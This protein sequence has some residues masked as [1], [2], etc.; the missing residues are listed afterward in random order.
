MNVLVL[1]PYPEA[2]LPALNEFKDSWIAFTKPLSREFCLEKNIDF[3]I[4]YG[5]RHILNNEVL[6]LFPQK[7]I[8]LHM[9]MLPCSR[10]AHPNFWSIAEGMP[11]GVTIHLLDEGLDTGNILIQREV[12]LDR[13][14]DTF[15]SSYN[16]L[17][18]SIEALF[19]ANW[20]YLRTAESPGWKQQGAP[21]V[22]RSSE[23]NK[24]LD[25]LPESWDT[26]IWRFQQLAAMRSQNP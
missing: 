20:K 18:R 25:C 2:I 11:S 8:N 22:H 7:A 26:P 6:D 24:W 23:I 3:L 14:V 10:G 15:S 5:Y 1:S 21:T 17:S 9:S 4:S 19:R 16:A 12:P 13:K